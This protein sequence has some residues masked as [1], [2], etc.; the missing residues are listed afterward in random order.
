MNTNGSIT[1]KEIRYLLPLLLALITFVY[2][3][4]NIS[5]NITTIQASQIDEKVQVSQ[6]S[7]TIDLMKTVQAQQGQ[8]IAVIKEILQHNNLTIAKIIPNQTLATSYTPTAG[9]SAALQTTPAP[10][11]NT[12][13]IIVQP[14]QQPTPQPSQFPA[15]HNQQNIPTPTPNIPVSKLTPTPCIVTFLQLCI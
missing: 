4:A 10:V 1:W 3:L 2:F 5:S 15:M 9:S 12:T 11:Q 14:T 6:L 8:D 13:I 7:N